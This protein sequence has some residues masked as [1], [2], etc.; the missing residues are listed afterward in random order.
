MLCQNCFRSIVITIQRPTRVFLIRSKFM[1]S[2][3]RKLYL[4]AFFAA[5]LATAALAQEDPNPNSPTPSL[6]SSP[7]RSRVLALNTRGWD[8]G[9][10]ASGGTVFRPSRT[11][12]ITIFVS[13][14]QL[15]PGEGANAVRVYLIQRSGKIFELRSDDLVPVGK[16][17]HAINFKIWDP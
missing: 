13:N 6:L 16:G 2:V 5:M 15:M 1:K 17:I 10:P 8:G 12:S 3:F 7:D 4:F 11:N 14:L 9:I